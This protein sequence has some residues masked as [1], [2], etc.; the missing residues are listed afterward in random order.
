M[1]QPT[2]TNNSNA[3]DPNGAARAAAKA[4]YKT[5]PRLAPIRALGAQAA[6]HFLANNPAAG[7]ASL[8]Q[9]H[10]AMQTLQFAELKAAGVATPPGFKK[11]GTVKKTGLALV[12][13]GERILTAKQA[14]KYR[15]LKP[16]ALYNAHRNKSKKHKHAK[17]S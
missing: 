8:L 15:A 2:Y 6:A 13:K 17:K 7:T 3:T 4:Q 16:G 5:D 10:K 11:G 14:R 9:A 12:H 1:P